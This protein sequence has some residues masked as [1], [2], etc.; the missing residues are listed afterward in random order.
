MALQEYLYPTNDLLVT[1][2][3]GSP[4][5]SSKY[6][7]IDEGTVSFSDV[8]TIYLSGL[9][10]QVNGRHSCQF[11]TGAA[12]VLPSSTLDVP[13]VFLNM[14]INAS[15]S[16]ILDTG[17]LWLERA[18]LLDSNSGVIAR[19]NYK[20]VGEPTYSWPLSSVFSTNN[21]ILSGVTTNSS[22]FEN[23]R[24]D[25]RLSGNFT[26]NIDATDNFKVSISAMEFLS[27]GVIGVDFS[28]MPLFIRGPGAVSDC[29]NVIDASGYQ[30]S[31]LI[32]RDVWTKNPSN[33][34]TY[35]ENDATWWM[36][37]G[38]GVNSSKSNDHSYVAVGAS[39]QTIVPIGVSGRGEESASWNSNNGDPLFA[40]TDIQIASISSSISYANDDSYFQEQPF[41]LDN[42]TP[43]P[44][45][46][47]KRPRYNFN[48]VRV[49][50]RVAKLYTDNNP[51]IR[52][53]ILKNSDGV[54]L[55]TWPDDE[56]VIDTTGFN[57]RY[58]TYGNMHTGLDH[59][60]LTNNYLTFSVY[61]V[62]TGLIIPSGIVRFA[63]IELHFDYNHIR[64]PNFYFHAPT[65]NNTNGGA[66]VCFRVAN[67][68]INTGFVT[69]S[70]ITL[71]NPTNETLTTFND[72]T[73]TPGLSYSWQNFCTNSISNIASSSFIDRSYMYFTSTVASGYSLY[74]VLFSEIE[75]C[76][77][78]IE[79]DASSCMTL[80]TTTPSSAGPS[81]MP[82][83][84]YGN[85]VS[86]SGFTLFEDGYGTN[87]SGM[88]LYEVGSIAVNS[89]MSLYEVGSIAVNSG[90]SL[91]EY[92]FGS[93]NSGMSLYEGAATA[94]NSGMSL[95]EVGSIA[96]NSGM[97]LYEG[98]ATAI[99]SGMSLY[100]VGSIAVNSG[101][102][103]YEVGS[104][105]ISSLMPLFLKAD[106]ISSIN[107]HT[108]LFT[109]STTN[110]GIYKTLPIYIG[111]SGDTNTHMPLYLRGPLYA[112]ITSN[113]VLFLKGDGNLDGST[114]ISSGISMFLGNNWIYQNSGL[115]L[116]VKTQEGTMGAVPVSSWM[117]LFINR[118][119]NSTA[120]IISLYMKVS[121]IGIGNIPMIINGA[122]VVNS[123]VPL[124]ISNVYAPN[125]SILP[126]YSRGF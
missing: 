63:E 95:Y 116:Y 76:V 48:Y 81:V 118:Q 7:N 75:L 90:L 33:P 79:P 47:F 50:M 38:S 106:T 110:S 34:T 104:I 101:M 111:G 61:D 45:I 58:S 26:A 16:N 85:E 29:L 70:D 67:Q 86:N 41:D 8:D 113:M 43:S 37:V 62:Q 31:D 9:V 2:F 124:T 35:V 107:S 54:T 112:D 36:A 97:S 98:G 3:S 120:D 122:Y 53:L 114:T 65:I 82:L 49:G 14:R 94:I 80:Y 117:P 93:S 74:D 12:H 46:L 15:S 44:Q 87:N 78:G 22:F 21:I 17:N 42:T 23:T 71:K 89:G 4:N 27:S 52:D 40:N 28:G 126:L 59:M 32:P 96:V 1:E 10:T 73:F 92:G 5:N 72:L 11:Y 18:L 57:N 88:S 19:Y 20:S 115:N 105:P 56:I 39:L 77:I 24:C 25:I 109:Y 64:S 108:K 91:Y 69:L 123:G 66:S 125:S 83:Y 100:E 121:D 68:N 13:S 51:K 102:S 103:L 84:T 60:S 6:T 55:A 119:T 30:V 99:N